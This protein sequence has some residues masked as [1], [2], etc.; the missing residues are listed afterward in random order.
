[1][2][3]VRSKLVLAARAR[4]FAS[5]I[6]SIV[7]DRCLVDKSG[8]MW[9]SHGAVV[10]FRNGNAGSTFNLLPGYRKMMIALYAATVHTLRQR[11]WGQKG[12]DNGILVVEMSL[13]PL[14]VTRLSMVALVRVLLSLSSPAAATEHH[15][16][17]RDIL[18]AAEALSTTI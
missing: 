1:M 5:E 11:S 16:V 12:T 4:Y 7:I 13:L 9:V 15:T 2:L 10:L 6:Y 17:S 8:N 14:H 18:S 3:F